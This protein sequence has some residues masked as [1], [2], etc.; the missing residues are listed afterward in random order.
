MA[1]EKQIYRRSFVKKIRRVK[2]A[3][4]KNNTENW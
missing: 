1:Y 3:V 2:N 4:Y